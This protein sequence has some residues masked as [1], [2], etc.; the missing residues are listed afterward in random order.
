VG[1]V[2]VIWFGERA[3]LLR[4][5]AGRVPAVARSLAGARLA[6]VIEIV[7]ASETVQV[8][9]SPEADAETVLSVAARVAA[10]A[11]ESPA[12]DPPRTVTIP[13]CYDADLAPDLG[14]IA[15]AAGLDASA[16]AALHASADYDVRF[17]GFSPGFAYLDGLPGPLH[18]PR[19]ETPRPR[20]HA[21]SVG[22]AGGRTA[23]YPMATPGGWRLIGATPL[24]V[25][26]PRREPASLLR[27]GDRVRFEPITRAE[28]EA[29][30]AACGEAAGC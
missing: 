5:G 10:G 15:R 28:Y 21:G 25:F 23:V 1:E 18:A 26:D 8:V 13:V 22:V 17:V 3:A 14:A 24:R 6:G 27:P 4:V 29:G 20:V 16:A 2:R 9:L 11:L 30:V 12:D 19:L 7:P